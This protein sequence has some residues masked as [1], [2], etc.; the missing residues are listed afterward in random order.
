MEQ[1][2]ARSLSPKVHERIR[3]LGEQEAH[4]IGDAYRNTP[5]AYKITQLYGDSQTLDFSPWYQ[6]CNFVWVDA[7]HDYAYVLKDTQEDL[8]LWRPGGWTGWHDSR[9]T[10]WW[11]GVIRAIREFALTH[12]GVRRR[13]GTTIALF[14]T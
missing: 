2:D 7:C 11:F 9:H 3:Q 12:P 1:V 5:E 6:Q 8:K 10:A 14:Q 4:N 13:R